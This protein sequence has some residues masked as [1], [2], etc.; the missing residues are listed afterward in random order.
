MK[1]VPSES[2]IFAP[3]M[4]PE[5]TEAQRPLKEAE[6]LVKPVFPKFPVLNVVPP[7]AME[8]PT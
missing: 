5:P 2:L 1:V 7:D 6:A 8:V 3:S 4:N